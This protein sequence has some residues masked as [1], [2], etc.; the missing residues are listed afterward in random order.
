MI[1][2]KAVRV[3][4]RLARAVIAHEK[5]SSY[6]DV[7][8]NSTDDREYDIYRFGNNGMQRPT[9]RN[10]IRKLEVEQET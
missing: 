4:I 7:C 2:V 6:R 3:L 1:T 8:S 5:Q 10:K 9:K